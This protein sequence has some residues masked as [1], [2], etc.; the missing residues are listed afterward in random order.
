MLD[1]ISNMSPTVVGLITSLIGAAATVI[2]ALIQ[3]R[4]AWSKELKARAE[5]RPVTKKAKRGPVLAVFV[6]S[7]ASAVG[8]FAL[9]Q[10]LATDEIRGVETLKSELSSRIDQ[11]NLSTQRLENV[12]L[13]GKDDLLRQ[14]RLEEALHHGMDGEAAFIGVGKCVAAAEAEAKSCNEQHALNLQLCAEVPATA[15]VSSINLYARTDDESRSWNESQVVAGYDFGSGRY[16]EKSMERSLSDS[17]KQV[18][19]GL[20]YW[21]SETGLQARMVVHYVPNLGTEL[22]DDKSPVDVMPLV[23][24]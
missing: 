2:V 20:S 5:N 18:C 14:V 7:L 10:Y 21:N 16:S 3:M 1:A 22:K 13:F 9:S 11:L 15:T 19:H 6:L 4:I 23:N 17:L 24:Q 12:R 8:G